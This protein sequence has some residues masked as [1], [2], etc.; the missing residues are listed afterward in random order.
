[1]DIVGLA[2]DATEVLMDDLDARDTSHYVSLAEQLVKAAEGLDEV[3]E[4]FQ[5]VWAAW[6]RLADVL[7][8]QSR[9]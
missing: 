7:R 8:E 2:E 1:M 4:Q 6:I 5:V 9:G 3:I